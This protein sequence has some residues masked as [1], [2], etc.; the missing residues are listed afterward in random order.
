MTDPRRATIT[1]CVE[2]GYD[3]HALAVA[4][5][6]VRGLGDRLSGLELIPWSDGTFDVR[7]GER[8]LHS[9]ARDGGLPEPAAMLAAARDALEAAT[10]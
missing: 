5:A 4:G 6:L 9:M 1:Y 8:L 10:A 2:C 3:E 7:L